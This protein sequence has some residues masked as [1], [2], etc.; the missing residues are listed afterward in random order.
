MLNHY[1]VHMKLMWHVSPVL[2]FLKKIF[3]KK[4][5]KMKKKGLS[6]LTFQNDMKE[7]VLGKS[8]GWAF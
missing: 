3:L 6:E 1:V 7:C 4:E 2:K 8:R 5:E